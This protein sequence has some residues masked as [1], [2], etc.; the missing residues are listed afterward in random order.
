LEAVKVS[1]AGEVISM[2]DFFNHDKRITLLENAII[3]IDKRFDQIEKQFEQVDKRFDK[4]DARFERLENKMDSQF[5]WLIGIMGGLGLTTIS[6]LITM[7]ARHS[8]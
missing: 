4:V 7:I 2:K 8:S 5:K 3:H 6:T 1:K